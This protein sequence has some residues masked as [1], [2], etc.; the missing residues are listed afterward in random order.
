MAREAGT[1]PSPHLLRSVG[2]PFAAHLHRC[3]SD[4]IQVSALMRSLSIVLLTAV[5]AA[6]CAC[7]PFQSVPGDLCNDPTQNYAPEFVDECNHR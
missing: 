6:V 7:A 5:F 3:A 4:Q 2:G 1:G